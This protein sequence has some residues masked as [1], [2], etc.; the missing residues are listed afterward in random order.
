MSLQQPGPY[1]SQVLS[2]ILRQTRQW[3]DRASTALRRFKV[4]TIWTVQVALYPVYFVFQS[5]RLVGTQI[6]QAVGLGLPTLQAWALDYA[7][8][9]KSQNFEKTALQP[10]TSLTAETPIQQALLTVSNFSLPVDLPVLVEPKETLTE[11]RLEEPSTSP[12][13][14]RSMKRL[15]VTT[16]R[17]WLLKLAGRQPK[18]DLGGELTVASAELTTTSRGP[19]SHP[20]AAAIT[21]TKVFVRGIASLL[22]SQALVLVTNQNQVL[23]V[24]TSE[25]QVQLRQKIAWETAHYGRYLRLRQATR[26]MLR[27][28]PTSDNPHVLL[29]VRLF[30]KLMAWVQF[31]PIAI[32]TNLFQEA[33][34]AMAQER[35]KAVSLPAAPVLPALPFQ[36]SLGPDFNSLFPGGALA[37]MSASLPFNL[38]TALSNPFA[39]LPSLKVPGEVSPS[40]NPTQFLQG[41]EFPDYLEADAIPIGYAL[42][43]LEKVM[44]WLDRFLL[45]LEKWVTILW[46]W[47]LNWLN[48]EP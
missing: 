32:A 8:I 27:S 11:S 39:S 43:P 17:S 24:L 14:F 30:Q 13:G 29:P 6:Q 21:Q 46:N 26:Q 12:L 20:A 9:R 40:F 2:G 19:L 10:S 4:S 25:Q 35:R 15:V 41:D 22:E 3:I 5:I 44:R 47:L 7:P 16:L 28:R 42:S 34:L 37:S 18:A 23:D 38:S 48:K 36:N 45:W 31:S 1:Q 33:S